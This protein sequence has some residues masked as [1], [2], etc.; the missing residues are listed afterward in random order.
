[1]DQWHKEKQRQKTTDNRL[2]QQAGI[3]VRLPVPSVPEYFG[4]LRS[5]VAHICVQ[6]SAIREEYAITDSKALAKR[7]NREGS[8]KISFLTDSL[9]LSRTY[10]LL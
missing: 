2:Q 1:M 8:A 10:H 9:A 3:Q 7:D 4:V 6:T 5:T